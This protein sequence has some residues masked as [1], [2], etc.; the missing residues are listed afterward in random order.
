MKVKFLMIFLST[1]VMSGF[2]QAQTKIIIMSESVD[3]FPFSMKNK[4]GLDFV[5]LD[6]VDKKLADVSF[7][8]KMVPWQRCLDGTI[9]NTAQGCFSASFKTKR[10][11]FGH[12]PMS[13]DKGNEAQSLHSS[14]YTL[15]VLKANAG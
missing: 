12:Y 5:L 15:Y 10:F 1:F 14:S 11:E 8:Y 4:T 7:E 9:S 13:G 2:T 3:S 6:F